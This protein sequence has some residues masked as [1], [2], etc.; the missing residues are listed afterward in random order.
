MV[1]LFFREF[2]F[3]IRK[4]NICISGTYRFFVVGDKRN[5]TVILNDFSKRLCKSVSVPGKCNNNKKFFLSGKT[6]AEFQ[7]R[8]GW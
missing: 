6:G 8:P 7:R 5:K 4:I 2:V 3:G 1:S